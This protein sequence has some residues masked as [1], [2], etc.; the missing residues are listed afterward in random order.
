MWKVIL[1]ATALGL[2]LGGATCFAQEI[3]ARE[4]QLSP[5]ATRDDVKTT[6]T[7]QHQGSQEETLV[8][9]P[10]YSSDKEKVGRVK[11]VDQGTDGTINALQAEIDGFLGLGSS[12]V[13]ITSD[14][15]EQKSDRIVLAKTA[16]QV[17]GVP[18]ES[19]E[20]FDRGLST[21]GAP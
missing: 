15:F 20:S 16:D 6:E 1:L 10:I 2:S 11:S 13:R 9:L 3:T 18:D 5:S 17:R 14:Q 12:S 4:K 19:Y 7:P 21:P 8:G